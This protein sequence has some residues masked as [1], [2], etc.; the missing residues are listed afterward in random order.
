MI[1]NAIKE[2]LENVKTLFMG[3]CTSK[4]SR[5]KFTLAKQDKAETTPLCQSRASALFKSAFPKGE[6]IHK[7]VV[8]P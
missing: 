8:H 7:N 5:S 4:T 1:G 3:K 2:Y 6:N